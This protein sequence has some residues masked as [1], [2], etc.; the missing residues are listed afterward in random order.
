MSEEASKS[1]RTGVTNGYEQPCVHSALN[2]STLHEQVLFNSEPSLQPLNARGLVIVL[3]LETRS[4]YVDQAVLELRD[5]LPSG[6][7]IKDVYHH[8]PAHESI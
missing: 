5:L 3:V 8:H 4:H 2:P 1:P 6:V 7:G